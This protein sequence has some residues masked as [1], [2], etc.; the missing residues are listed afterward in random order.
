MKIEKFTEGYHIPLP[1]KK[2]LQSQY[3]DNDFPFKCRF[4][5]RTPDPGICYV[6]E[7][8]FREKKI[9]WSNGAVGS[10]ANFEDIEFIPDIFIF[11]K[12]NL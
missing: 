5:N 3:N 4:K 1:K 6:T 9:E 2:P 12:Y 10:I 7:I 8:Y 11:D